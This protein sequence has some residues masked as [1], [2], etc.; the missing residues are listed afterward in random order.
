MIVTVMVTL[1]CAAA[2]LQAMPKLSTK[3][4]QFVDQSGKPF[5]L[6]GVNL[7]GWLVEEIWMTPVAKDPP[8]GSGQ[9]EIEDHYSLWGTIEQRLGKA[10]MER[11]R[12]AWRENWIQDSDFQRIKDL[13]LNHVRLPF[14]TMMLDEPNGIDWLKRGVAMAKKHGLRG[15][16]AEGD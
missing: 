2:V 10:A 7:G 14:L 1:L 12:T 6:R 16:E 15:N 4:E 5:A 8:A 3:G 9:K 11:V 13:G